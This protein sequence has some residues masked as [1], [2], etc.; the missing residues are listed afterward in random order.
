MLG[1]HVINLKLNVQPEAIP[2]EKLASPTPSSSFMHQSPALRA[3][4]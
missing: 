1:L 4:Y 2:G 3:S